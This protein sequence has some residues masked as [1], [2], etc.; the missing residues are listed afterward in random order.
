MVAS[1]CFSPLTKLAPGTW[2]SLS[3]EV[4]TGPGVQV[5]NV[6]MFS[7]GVWWLTYPCWLCGMTVICVVSE[8]LLVRESGK[9]VKLREPNTSNKQIRFRKQGWFQSQRK[10]LF[11]EW[12]FPVHHWISQILG[13]DVFRLEP[14]ADTGIST[15]L[16]L[17]HDGLPQL[18][19]NS[20]H[21]SLR[22]GL[23]VCVKLVQSGIKYTADSV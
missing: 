3:L 6:C 16:W 20:K 7:R 12:G 23:C 21:A 10:A 9:Q 4:S 22:L 17:G 1:P 5:Y 2:S 11:K 19:C 15:S 14:V 18:P 8:F 13:P